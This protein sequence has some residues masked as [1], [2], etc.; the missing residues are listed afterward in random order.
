MRAAIAVLLVG[1]SAGNAA[2]PGIPAINSVNFAPVRT[3]DWQWYHN[4]TTGE[5]LAASGAVMLWS[6][7]TTSLAGLPWLKESQRRKWYV[8]IACA[9]RGGAALYMAG[10]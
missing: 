1:V 2:C 5:R 10:K 7:T 6:S 4:G 9:H 3:A 8:P